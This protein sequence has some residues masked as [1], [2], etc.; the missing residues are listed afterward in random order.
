MLKILPF[1]FI[2]LIGLFEAWVKKESVENYLG[3]DSGFLAYIWVIL[4]AGATVGGV[5]VVFLVAY[6]LYGKGVKLS[7]VF[8]YIGASAVY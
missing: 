2:L 3:R 8:T 1:A 5:Y 7:I 6:S 4:L